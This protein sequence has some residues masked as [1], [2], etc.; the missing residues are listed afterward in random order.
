MKNKLV[1]SLIVTIIL[2]T[3][4]ASAFAWG[5]ATHT[6]LA[7]ELGNKYGITNRLEMYGAVVP[8]MFNLMFGYE[9]QDYLFNQTH[10]NFM[11]VVERAAFGRKKAFA[12]GF[13]SHNEAW[14]ADATA[15]TTCQT[16]PVPGEG[17]VV[18]KR[19]ILAPLLE[20]EIAAFLAANSIPYTPELVEELAL[21]FADASVESAVDYLVSQNEDK[22]VGPEI[23]TAAKFRSPFVPFLLARAYAR[24]FAQQA[25]IRYFEA[26]IFIIN[27]EKQF[28]EYMELYGG[29]LT[30]ANALDLMAQQ[31]AQLAG[32]RLEKEYGI[33][34]TVPTELM[35]D[36]LEAAILIVENDYDE[37]LAAT[38]EYVDEQLEFHGIETYPW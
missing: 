1:L 26:V 15:S 31:G 8:D 17:Y 22:Q 29:I 25:G 36:A 32:E 18:I 34:V 35:K 19:K 6:Y 10:Y 33:I 11:K 3:T 4:P 24:D 37:E 9:Y 14:A 5:T 23:L 13:V 30:Q 12:Y 16:I 27:T 28:K 7:K 38:L 21:I 20:P 2:A